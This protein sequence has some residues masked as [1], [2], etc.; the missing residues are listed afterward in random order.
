MKKIAIVHGDCQNGV[1]KKAVEV[2]SQ[3]L[4]DYTLEYPVCLPCG[5][6]ANTFNGRRIYIGTKDN[7][8][9]IRQHARLD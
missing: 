1:Q 5:E 4:L 9:W 6:R 3:L 2:L 7:S 8:A